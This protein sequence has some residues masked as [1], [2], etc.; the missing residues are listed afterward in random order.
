MRKT[1]TRKLKTWVVILL[2]L[3]ISKVF[4]TDVSLIIYLYMSISFYIVLQMIEFD[5]KKE[6]KN[7]SNPT[8]N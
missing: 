7:K 1:G 8:R 5:T 2:T 4:L 3:I 6:L